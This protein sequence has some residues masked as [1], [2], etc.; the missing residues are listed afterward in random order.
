MHFKDKGMYRGKMILTCTDFPDTRMI[1]LVGH[2]QEKTVPTVDL[3]VECFSNKELIQELPI[4]NRTSQDWVVKAMF[5]PANGNSVVNGP[6][7]VS[8][9]AGNIGTY[10][11]CFRPRVD[12]IGRSFIVTL[13]L[14][15]SGFYQQRFILHVKPV[16]DPE[17]PK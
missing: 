7:F 10:P 1:E 16:E 4:S 8:V 12:D 5:E 6:S 13:M 11:I 15:S 2:V 3:H 17:S 14:E 9:K